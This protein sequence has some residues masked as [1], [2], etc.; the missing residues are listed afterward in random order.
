MN[1]AAHVEPVRH[2]A[3]VGNPNCGKTALFNRLTGSRQKVA[4]YTGVTVE[5][6]EG[7]FTAPSGRHFRLLDLPGTWRHEEGSRAVEQGGDD[8]ARGAV[9]PGECAKR[10]RALR[11]VHRHGD[12]VARGCRCQ[13]SEARE[14]RRQ[15]VA[16][17]RRV[18]DQ[19]LFRR[20]AMRERR[21]L[22]GPRDDV[23]ANFC[24][25]VSCGGSFGGAESLQ[26][27]ADANDGQQRACREG[28]PE[29]A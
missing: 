9:A 12:V 23:L 28:D 10:A 20:H 22:F 19:R 6:K 8:A 21:D 27:P 26:L 3:L 24:F 29:K 25:E 11:H 4:N 15:R 17:G 1:A 5:R 14:E 7:R 18:L 16:R 2:L 13:F